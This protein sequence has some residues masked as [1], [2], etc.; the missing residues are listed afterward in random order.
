[1]EI[2][3]KKNKIMTNNPNGISEEV[4]VSG[5]KLGEVSSFKY[6]EAIV[7]DEGSKTEVLSRIAQISIAIPN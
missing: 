1:M 6:L 2:S 4:V 5:Q 3:A 7:T